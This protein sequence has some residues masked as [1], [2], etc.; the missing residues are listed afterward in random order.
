[1]WRVRWHR[2]TVATVSFDVSA[3]A[4]GRFMGRFSEPLAPLF[5]DFAGVAGSGI[6]GHGVA[7]TVLDVGCGPGALTQVL[8]ARLDEAAVAAV[9]PSESFVDAIG[10]RFPG[11]DVRHTDAEHLPFEDGAF[12]ATLAQLVV[13]FMDDPVR[14]LR[15]MK[16]VTRPDG[17]VAACF[18]GTPSEGS[19]LAPFWEAVRESDPDAHNIDLRSGSTLQRLLDLFEQAG[20]KA[21]YGEPITFRT[22][23]ETFHAWWDPFTLGVGPAGEYVAELD[24][25]HAAELRER[26]RAA[27]PDGP[28]TISATAWAVRARR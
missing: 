8:V 15:E 7:R 17:V 22:G 6:T 4:Y 1:V 11:V 25:E 20:F 12:G 27:L 9:D 13:L 16:R 14:G 28:F 26:C 18:W 3:E 5:A 24:R 2:S 23:F 19:P 10:R 21:P